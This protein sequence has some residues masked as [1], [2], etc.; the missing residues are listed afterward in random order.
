MRAMSASPASMKTSSAPRS[1]ASCTSRAVTS[2]P[3][4]RRRALGSVATPTIALTSPTGWWLPLASTPPSS[5]ATAGLRQPVADPLAEEVQ[6]DGG[7]ADGRRVALRRARRA[8]GR[9]RM[10]EADV[11][12][13]RRS[14]ASAGSPGASSRTVIP[15]GRI[16]RAPAALAEHHQRRLA[17]TFSPRARATVE[18]A[19]ARAS[20]IHSNAS[21][22]PSSRWRARTAAMS[23]CARH[24]RARDRPRVVGPAGA[25]LDEQPQRAVVLDARRRPRD[26]VAVR[27]DALQQRA[28]LDA[29]EP[30]AILRRSSAL[31]SVSSSTPCSRATSR[32]VRPLEEASLT[33][34]AALS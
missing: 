9:A 30:A 23:S 18:Q 8:G 33:I 19:R 25:L 31:S 17:C 6:L 20:S 32:S 2:A 34:S 1:R 10:P 12:R 14:A 29:F 7:L 24:A 26:G 22:T 5:S 4:P 15:V 11:R 3:S 16:G 27:V 21:G 28:Q 13:P